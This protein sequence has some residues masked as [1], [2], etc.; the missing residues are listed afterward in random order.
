[1]NSVAKK[2]KK[3]LM[4]LISSSDDNEVL[5]NLKCAY[6][7]IE[8]KYW[9]DPGSKF[10]YPCVFVYSESCLP[11]Y[12]GIEY[13]IVFINK[14]KELVWLVPGGKDPKDLI[15]LPREM[16]ESVLEVSNFI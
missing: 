8:S 6:N 7:D 14:V 13:Q 12:I 16:I 3:T 11:I 15:K 1:M 2:A 9:F 10:H 5:N 4:V